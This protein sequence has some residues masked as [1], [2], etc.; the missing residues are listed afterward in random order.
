MTALPSHCHTFPWLS[1]LLAQSR[2]PKIL[3]RSASTFSSADTSRAFFS[4]KWPGDS[5]STFG[6]TCCGSRI[7]PSRSYGTGPR[8]QHSW[9]T[10]LRPRRRH[11]MRACARSGGGSDSRSKRRRRRRTL[12]KGRFAVG[13][14]VSVPATVRRCL[15]PFWTTN[16]RNGLNRLLIT[17]E[18]RYRAVNDSGGVIRPLPFQFRQVWYCL[19]NPVLRHEN[20]LSR[21]PTGQGSIAHLYRERR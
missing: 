8:S 4:G 6:P 1:G 17:T 10:I 12:M 16:D 15:R 19:R 2:T 9:D 20:L 11:G 13:S 3:P 7:G 14:A 21:S 5:V 18:S